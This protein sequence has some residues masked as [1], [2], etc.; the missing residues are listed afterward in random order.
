M[1]SESGRFGSW[2]SDDVGRPV[3][4]VELPDESDP[5]L[6]VPTAGP[7]DVWH[8]VGSPGLAALAHAS[9]RISLFATASGMARLADRSGWWRVDGVEVLAPSAAF[10]CGW[11][12]WRAEI[13]GASVSR[14]IE[15]HPTDATLRLRW[16]VL[17]DRPVR[18][19]EDWA[20]AHL[21]LLAGP[22]MSR[23]VP[24]P[25]T[26]RGTNRVL[27]VAVF[28]FTGAARAVTD[29]VRRA[30]GRRYP[31][32]ARIDPA[33]RRVI[34]SPAR[35]PRPSS[36]PAWFRRDLPALVLEATGD[37]NVAVTGSGM[38]ITVMP[39]RDGAPVTVDL[40]LRLVGPGLPD[41]TGREEPTG[42]T[43]EA[44]FRG[45][46][47]D[48][49]GADDLK[50]EA[51]WHLS[52]LRG[53]RVPDSWTGRTFVMQGSAYAFVHGLHGAPRDAAFVAVPLSILDPPTAREVV[54]S[55][56]AMTRADGSLHYAHTGCGRV[57]SAGVHASPTDLPLFL[58][59][60]L[61]EYTWATG[62][63][64][65][66]DERPRPFGRAPR[67]TGSTPSMGEL[68]VAACRWIREAVGTGPH[69]MLRVGSGDWA[70]PISLMVPRRASFRR[71]GES[72]FNTGMALYVLPRAATLL[73]D[74]DPVEAARTRD[75]AA[76]LDHALAAAWTGR[77]FLRGWDGRGHP[78]GEEHCFLD[79]QVWPLIARHGDPCRR[80]ALVAG[81]GRLLDDPSPIGP[82]ILDRPHRVR[83]GL[84]ADGWDCNG[85]V[86]S[87]IGGLLA[88]GYAV[89]DIDRAWATLRKQS[90]AAHAAA[91][92]NVWYGQWS[93]PDAYNAWFGD[94]AGE[95]F[96][97]P[98]TPM[99]E[100]PVMNSNAHAG[101]L[102]GLLRTLGITVC[103]DG[104][105]GNHLPRVAARSR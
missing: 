69:G 73:G 88:W 74:R 100:F 54:L 81:I 85:G 47:L 9:G 10:G 75:F 4:R 66:L 90:F 56:G 65:V 33:G 68:A 70:D 78:I 96:V 39:R 28:A 29:R 93:G 45:V 62:D 7:A 89:H 1:S 102:L 18:V 27:W 104:I 84:L 24:V 82:T 5:G 23:P 13:V 52:Q 35:T 53:L 34:W 95:T 6:I 63:W 46:T 94:R 57:V 77:W 58:L 59:W 20:I 32:R 26:H 11:A 2:G 92:P 17:A 40:L 99:T 83:L 76:E 49:A 48:V 51:A 44:S 79:G 71:H 97:Q 41:P 37:A 8:L 21:P 87:A 31:L 3:F 15:A 67:G 50:A 43:E 16:S 36:G 101:P 105:E 103:P 22:L 25:S 86:W 38:E 12:E 64:A 55:I 72:G 14:R 98:A 91:Y 30:L 19:S 42:F 80:E 60:A 61:T